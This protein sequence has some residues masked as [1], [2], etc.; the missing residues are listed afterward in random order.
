M[1]GW[2]SCRENSKEG[3]RGFFAQTLIRVRSRVV[4]LT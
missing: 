1:E 4:V 2:L 3:M